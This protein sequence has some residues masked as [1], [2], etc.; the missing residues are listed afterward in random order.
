MSP[1][2]LVGSEAEVPYYMRFPRSLSGIVREIG[3]DSFEMET[4]VIYSCVVSLRLSYRF[5]YNFKSYIFIF[6]GEK[7]KS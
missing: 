2:C 7:I 3:F 6:D 1:S 5:E 4:Y